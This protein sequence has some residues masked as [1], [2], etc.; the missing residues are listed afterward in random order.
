MSGP[1]RIELLREK[2]EQAL[3]DDPEGV[4]PVKHIRDDLEALIAAD[5]WDSVARMHD[6]K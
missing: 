1:S 5:Y 4:V 2:Y 6:T 3:S